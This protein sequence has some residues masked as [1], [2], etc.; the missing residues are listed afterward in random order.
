MYFVLYRFD[1]ITVVHLSS[2]LISLNCRYREA[3]LSS[4][5]IQ[6]FK[7]IIYINFTF[8]L[9]ANMIPKS[10]SWVQIGKL[11]KPMHNFL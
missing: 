10:F 6:G 2:T 1:F 7:E 4:Q 5:L 11:R 8:N 3:A 9:G